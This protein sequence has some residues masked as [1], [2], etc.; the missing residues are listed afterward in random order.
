LAVLAAMLAAWPVSKALAEDPADPIINLFLQKGFIT[1]T[2]AAKAKA[3][4]QA[5]R[6]NQSQEMP[7]I[8]E[9]KWKISEGIKSIQMFGDLRLRYEDRR[10]EDPAGG[11]I[12]LQRFRYS[13]RLGIRGEVF[14]DFN[15]GLRI[16]TSANP[17]S[18]WVTFGTSSS[19][20][21]YQGPFGK[22]TAG[23]AVGQ[24]YIGYHPANWVDLTVGKMPNPL[25]TTPMVWDPDINPEGAAEHF[26]YT[27]GAADV[28]ATFGQF[29]YQDVNPSSASGGLGFNGLTG[30]NANNVFQLAFQGGFTYHFTTNMSVKVAPSVYKYLG[31]QRS[32]VTSPNVNSPFFGDP[33]IG[34]GVYLGPGTGTINGY[35]GFGTSSTLPGY[36]SLG[37]PLNQVGLN[38]LLVIDVPFEFDFKVHHL[39]ARVFGDFAYNLEGNNRA[40]AAAAGYAAWLASQPT[41]PTIHAFSPQKN[42][43]KAYQI[44]LAIGNEGGWDAHV[45][46]PWEFKTF[47]QHTEQY[48]LDPNIIDSDVFEGRENMEGVNAQIAYGFTRNVIASI[49]YAHGSRIDKK[50]GTGGSNQDI[51]QIN[52]INQFDLLQLDLTLKY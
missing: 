46:H 19:G 30:Q 39:D 42:Q 49:R 8:P 15:Y 33:Y 52:A 11:S 7:H 35:S 38:D 5:I 4:M 16:E 24:I 31:L 9:S 14:D 18:S 40:K 23:I 26:K 12:D 6:T 21:P 1:E 32:S 29:L 50:I 13:L 43:D 20:T 47:W 41:P 27:V 51:P 44:G 48:A 2:E 3:E 25:Y 22:S 34:E 10:A 17:R 45:R 36:G 28:F 37:F